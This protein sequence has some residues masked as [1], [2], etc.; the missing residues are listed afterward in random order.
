MST[1]VLQ[2][3]L[4]EAE[5]P[6]TVVSVVAAI[7]EACRAI[8]ADL[9]TDTVVA[10]QSS[11]SFGDEVLSVDVMA[12]RHIATKLCDCSAVATIVSEERPVL[13]PTPNA[14]SGLYTVSYDPLDGSSI[15]ATN[16]SVGSIFAVWPGR[17][18]IGLQVRD[19]VASVVSLYGPRTVLFVAF[20]PTANTTSTTSVGTVLRFYLHGNTWTP[21]RDSVPRQ[22]SK[23]AT[24]FAPGNL[25]ASLELPWY[26][27]IVLAYMN[28][29]ATLRYTGGMVPDV[30]QIVVKGDGVYMTPATPNH[31]MKLRL[32]FEA[33]P[34]TF[35][36]VCA[37]G[38]ATTGHT[39]MMEVRVDEVEQR[40]AIALGSSWDVKRYERM[41]RYHSNSSNSITNKDRNNSDN[42][43]SKL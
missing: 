26:R 11:N 35:L 8:S 4:T 32:I 24:I 13:T 22:I 19:M 12:E 36:V 23:K 7:A 37:G 28:E 2:K 5:A 21:L 30:C 40:T 20:S 43:G 18:P 25:R 10:A 42:H 14:G 3:T 17:S 33:A 15:I 29:K 1:S 31:K 6:S 39:D 16:F 9:R 38:R 27:D 34:M 41:C